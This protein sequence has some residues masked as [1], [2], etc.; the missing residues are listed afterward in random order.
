VLNLGK[1]PT[2][3]SNGTDS[4]EVHLLDFSGDLYSQ[5]LEI[6]DFAFLRDEQA[7]SGAE[8]LKAQIAED[9][10]KARTILT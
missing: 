3:T 5:S 9:V 8:A 1:R 2:F 10:A 7:F 6:F 4:L